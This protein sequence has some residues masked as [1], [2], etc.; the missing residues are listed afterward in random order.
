MFPSSF[1]KGAGKEI[2]ELF[3]GQFCQQH[4]ILDRGAFGRLSEAAIGER[5]LIE[6]KC[7]ALPSTVTSQDKCDRVSFEFIEVEGR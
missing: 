1:Q 2:I 6:G 4:L 7:R 3:A 5:K